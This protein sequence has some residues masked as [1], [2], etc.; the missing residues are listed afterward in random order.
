M[1][2]VK[3]RN[4]NRQDAP[5][6][7]ANLCDTF[8]RKFRGLMFTREIDQARGVLFKDN[9]ETVVNSAIHMLFMN[10]D[11]CVV[12]MNQM[13][14]VVDVQIARKWRLLYKPKVPAC[15]TLELNICRF[16]DYSVGDTLEFEDA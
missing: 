2:I 10:Y 5:I 14:T 8:F 13:V 6:I 4:R 1:K 9:A 11:I 16:S 7:Q 15:Y 3:I 12:W